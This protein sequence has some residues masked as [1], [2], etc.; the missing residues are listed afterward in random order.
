MKGS[1]QHDDVIGAV[2]ELTQ[3][4]VDIQVDDVDAMSEGSKEGLR[5]DFDPGPVAAMFLKQ[6]QELSVTTSEV[7]HT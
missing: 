2:L 1:G 4:T 3:L 5:F 6:P 7:K